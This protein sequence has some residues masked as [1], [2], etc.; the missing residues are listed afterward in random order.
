[1]TGHDS[2]AEDFERHGGVQRIEIEVAVDPN[3][4]A[5]RE[6]ADGMGAQRRSW[7]GRDRLRLSA[8]TTA[9]EKRPSGHRREDGSQPG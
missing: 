6:D 1:V 8:G 3:K 5:G 9:G 2:S 4:V 7:G